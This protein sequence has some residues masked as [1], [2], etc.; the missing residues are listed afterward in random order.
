M[1]ICQFSMHLY[2]PTILEIEFLMPFS[3]KTRDGKSPRHAA[4]VMIRCS[5]YRYYIGI[6]C[7]IYFEFGYAVA[8]ISH[9]IYV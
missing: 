7:L 2:E 6:S 8:K 5:S 1:D 3:L 4:Q 9:R